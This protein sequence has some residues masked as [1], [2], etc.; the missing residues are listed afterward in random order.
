MPDRS[1]SKERITENPDTI[2]PETKDEKTSE[3]TPKE[4]ED[5]DPDVTSEELPEKK[6][7][8]K[9]ENEPEEN[10]E[11]ESEDETW[12]KYFRGKYL[13][14]ICT[15]FFLSVVAI[16]AAAALILLQPAHPVDPDTVV[17]I[18][19]KEGDTAKEI[20]QELEQ[21]GVI[22]NRYLFLLKAKLQ[23]SLDQFKKG[24]YEFH[25]GM[26]IE[27]VIDKLASGETMVVRF[28]IPEGF[29]LRQMAKRLSEKELVDEKKFLQLTKDFMP[30][31]YME[32]RQNA[33]YTAEGFLFP[34]T[35][36]VQ[37][38]MD[39]ESI[40][41]M[42]ADNLD[43][44]LTKEMR[45][46]AAEMNLSIYDLI[47][48]ASL[49]EREALYSEE[50][51]II[52]RVFFNRLAIDMPLQSCATIQYLLNE[53]KVELTIADTQI[54]SPYNTY[55]N[56]GLPP[57]PI[58]APGLESIQA[59]LYPADTNYLFFVADHEG[60]HHFSTTYAEHLNAIE[61]VR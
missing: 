34:D 61:Q 39:E 25:G 36:E 17:Q 33:D 21:S 13:F 42:M 53:P 37:S 30:Y 18:T 7:D 20:A 27:Q 16:G 14:A 12:Q 38:G 24:S 52:A 57:G 11:Q 15:V 55:L 22:P 41:Q 26:P 48:M 43:R 31:S 56:P 23:G 44:R 32:K 9:P 1:D 8:E 29:T 58:A 4:K 5:K 2:D 3:E 59:V 6:S 46:R 19:V 51:P 60:H 35:Y 28:T 54:D 47:T 10:Q 50:R 45:N 49:V 40:M